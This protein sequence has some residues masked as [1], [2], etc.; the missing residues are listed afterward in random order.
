CRIS[1]LFLQSL[2]QLFQ[3]PLLLL[4]IGSNSLLK[5]FAKLTDLITDCCF[6][7]HLIHYQ[8]V[9]PFAAP[10]NLAWRHPEPVEG[11]AN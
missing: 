9:T 7:Y 8:G 5:M 6:D 4:L 1:L 11:H 2:R 3:L 10:M